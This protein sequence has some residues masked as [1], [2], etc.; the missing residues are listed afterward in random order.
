MIPPVRFYLNPLLAKLLHYSARTGLAVLKTPKVRKK[1]T[2]GNT[3]AQPTASTSTSVPTA[4]TFQFHPLLPSTPL[5]KSTASGYRKPRRNESIVMSLNGSPLRLD[6]LLKRMG[7]KAVPADAKRGGPASGK[8]ART[9]EET[10]EEEE[11]VEEED[12]PAEEEDGL[13]LLDEEEMMRQMEDAK[14]MGRA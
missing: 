12:E 6:D 11:E 4:E 10:E 2:V 5:L 1:K 13:D 7:I 14:G 8:G 3:T 9:E